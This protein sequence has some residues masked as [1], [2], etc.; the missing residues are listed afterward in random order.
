ML[1]D[2]LRAW[3]EHPRPPSDLALPTVEAPPLHDLR[4]RVPRGEELTQDVLLERYDTYLKAVAPRTVRETGQ[5]ARAGDVVVVAMAAFGGGGALPFTAQDGVELV[6]DGPW[7]LPGI[8]EHLV[9]R[10]VD[11]VVD[12]PVRFPE[13]WP[14]EKLRGE[15][16]IYRMRV[17][18]ITELHLP[19][20]EDEE[21][22]PKL[23]I[24]LSMDELMEALRDQWVEDESDALVAEARTRVLDLLR[25]RS[26][27]QVPRELVEREIWERW[28]Q[29]EGRVLLELGAGEADL[30]TSFA[31]WLRSSELAEDITRRIH[32]SLLLGAI[33]ARDGLT[34]E[35]ED[36]DAVVDEAADLLDEDV[37][38][39]RAQLKQDP[40][41]LA[42]VMNQAFHQK[43]V[44]HVMDH[45]EVSFRSR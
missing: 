31:A 38:D 26:P 17:R 10:T 18:S 32:I 22:L 27:V 35:V 41:R 25:G 20:P 42:A 39:V 11:E 7:V 21:L 3:L 13:D 6:A 14:A 45:A 34:L 28:A 5:F 2:R 36:V 37:D 16:A 8:T 23:G 24:A 43:V 9:G 4:V 40:D 1:V 12:V 15:T 19:D 44:Q 30:N 33:A 29:N